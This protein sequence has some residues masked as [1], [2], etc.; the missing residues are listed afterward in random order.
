[1]QDRPHATVATVI[2]QEGRFLL[3]RELDQEREVFNQPAGHL[4]HGE[5]LVD[6]AVRE[7]REETGWTVRVTGLLG[8]Y[9]YTSP[10]NGISYLRTCFIAEPLRHDPAAGLDAEIL[11]AVWLAPAEIGALEQAGKLRS[12]LVLRCIEDYLAGTRHPLSVLRDA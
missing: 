3:V 5:T 4:E 9:R 1:M 11:E 2:E 6:A 12:P 8:L 10:R 7:T